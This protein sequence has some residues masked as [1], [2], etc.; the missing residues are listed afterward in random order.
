MRDKARRIGITDRGE[1]LAFSNNT[2]SIDTSIFESSAIA[3]LAEILKD[4]LSVFQHFLP[5]FSI[6]SSLLFIPFFRNCREL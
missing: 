5:V 1:K 3:N 2:A 4:S 6:T